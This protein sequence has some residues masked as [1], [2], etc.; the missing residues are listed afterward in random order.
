M[1]I[2]RM[3]DVEHHIL[4][5]QLVIMRALKETMPK[6]ATPSVHVDLREAILENVHVI[7]E[8]RVMRSDR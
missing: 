1:A 3:T 6:G 7:R 8:A 2:M 5:N 4:R